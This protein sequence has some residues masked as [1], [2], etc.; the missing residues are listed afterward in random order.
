MIYEAKEPK[1]QEKFDLMI[2]RD[3]ALV[4]LK[5]AACQFEQAQREWIA[6]ADYLD[7]RSRYSGTPYKNILQARTD[8]EDA[9][10]AYAKLFQ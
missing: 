10:K 4:D 8:L 5:L 9:A 7:R 2:A 1:W 3:Q 6:S